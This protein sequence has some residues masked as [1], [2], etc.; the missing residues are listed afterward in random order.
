MIRPGIP[1]HK[2]RNIVTLLVLQHDQPVDR[3][4]A[5]AVWLDQQRIDLRF[6]DVGERAVRQA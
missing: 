6:R 1:P 5:L 3:H 2:P 4:D